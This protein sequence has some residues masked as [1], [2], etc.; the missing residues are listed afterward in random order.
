MP[1]YVAAYEL[2]LTHRTS[3]VVQLYV[4][5]SVF[6]RSKIPDLTQNKNEILA[7]VRSQRGP[8]VWFFS[9]IENFIHL[10]NTPDVGAQLG[11]SW[12]LPGQ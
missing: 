5:P 11:V 6:A 9:F 3:V 7:G 4:S 2:G 1:A 12:K 10:E 8:V